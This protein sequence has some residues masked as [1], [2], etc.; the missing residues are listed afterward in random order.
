MCGRKQN[1]DLWYILTFDFKTGLLNKGKTILPMS[2]AG[3]INL[4]IYALIKVIPLDHLRAYMLDAL[5]YAYANR[6]L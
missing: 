6:V 2:E 3:G 4:Y 5:L 1:T